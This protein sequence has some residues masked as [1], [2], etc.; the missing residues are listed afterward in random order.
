MDA[1][2][3][4]LLG[5]ALT[6]GAGGI[7]GVWLYMRHTTQ[8][9]I[10]AATTHADARI[11]DAKANYEARLTSEIASYGTRLDDLKTAWDRERQQLLSQHQYEIQTLRTELAEARQE[12]RELNTIVANAAASLEKNAASQDAV[13]TLMHAVIPQ[14][15]EKN[16][17]RQSRN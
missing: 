6:L 12:V 17:R 3:A 5:S 15:V 4:T 11:A 1:G 16:E 13:V 14:I 9:Q 7:G 10:T 2:I 8:Q